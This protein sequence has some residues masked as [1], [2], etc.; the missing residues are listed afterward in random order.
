MAN[1]MRQSAPQGATLVASAGNLDGGRYK[2]PPK[3]FR[4]AILRVVEKV[5]APRRAKTGAPLWGL[6]S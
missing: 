4:P 3:N 6:E 5:W 1:S 2:N